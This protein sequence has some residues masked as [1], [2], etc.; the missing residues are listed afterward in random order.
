MLLL[1]WSYE[2]TVT[3]GHSG[4]STRRVFVDDVLFDDEE[5]L[6]INAAGRHRQWN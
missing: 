5:V 4:R 6:I 2:E 1:L 3:A